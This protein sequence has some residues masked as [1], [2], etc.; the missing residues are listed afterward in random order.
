M[1]L[2]VHP[3][4]YHLGATDF[5][6][7]SALFHILFVQISM[8]F[9]ESLIK[10]LSG[11][12]EKLN[13]KNY[14]LW[15]QSFET[16]LTAYRKLRHL[17]QS[18]PDAKDNTYED[19]FADDSVIVSWLVNSMKP[20]VAWGVMILRLVKKIWDTLKQMYG[21]EKNI[22]RVFEVY[23]QILTLKMGGQFSTGSLWFTSGPPG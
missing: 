2:I 15:V 16:F 4:Y 18:P 14:F 23:E 19:W 11:T 20:T 7:F 3:S 5:G 22:S 1:V 10:N 17:T 21:Y 6:I 8:A 13:G 9:R 12:L